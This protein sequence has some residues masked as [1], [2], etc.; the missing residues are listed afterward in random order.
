MNS[1]KKSETQPL[2]INQIVGSVRSAVA[3]LVIELPARWMGMDRLIQRLEKDGKTLGQRVAA[4]R[5]SN[6]AVLAH[7]IGIERW[8][9]RRIRVAL[10]EPLSV[11]E[12]DRYRPA[13]TD[14][15]A[16]RS[17]FQNTRQ[18]T[19]SLCK[20]LR[21][22]GVDP[23]TRILHNQ[24]GEISLLGWFYYLCLHA[25]IESLRIY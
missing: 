2:N 18:G 22:A 20:S 8:G 23:Q 4:G 21:M 6:A 17:I 24:F 13:E 7:M 12:Y 19:I 11:E 10:G 3:A 25:R 14:I 15:S 16:L 9:Q 1:I 5:P